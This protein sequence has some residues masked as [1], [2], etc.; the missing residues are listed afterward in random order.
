MQVLAICDTY[1]PAAIFQSLN[2]AKKRCEK[3]LKCLNIFKTV[4]LKEQ[5]Q[6]TPY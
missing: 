6:F 2:S 4:I 3:H 5:I 1:A